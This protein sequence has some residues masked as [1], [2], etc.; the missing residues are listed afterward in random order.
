MYLA[1]DF[2]GGIENAWSNVAAFVAK[3]IARILDRILERVGFDPAVVGSVI[4]AVGGGGIRTMQRYWE[5]ATS[6]AEERAPQPRQQARH[7][8]APDGYHYD[9]TSIHPGPGGA[10]AAGDLGEAEGAGRRFRRDR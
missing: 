10:S 2:Q 3:L 8:A 4:V 9:T 5:R 1:V 6:R 7:P